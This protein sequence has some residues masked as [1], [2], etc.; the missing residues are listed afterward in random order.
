MIDIEIERVLSELDT[1]KSPMVNIVTDYYRRWAD[2]HFNG[3]KLSRVDLG[4][5]QAAEDLCRKI[6]AECVKTTVCPACLEN[7][8]EMVAMQ[9]VGQNMYQCPRCK[10]AYRN[11]AGESAQ[12]RN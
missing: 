6:H 8:D 3:P 5:M 9:V 10:R 2:Q 7:N 4:K 12:T 1:L 11:K